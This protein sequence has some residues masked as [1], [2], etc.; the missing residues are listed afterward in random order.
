MPVDGMQTKD[1]LF[2]R[3]KRTEKGERRGE[4]RRGKKRGGRKRGEKK[5]KRK[6]AKKKR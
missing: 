1:R 3:E 5:A 6:E 4:E 2:W